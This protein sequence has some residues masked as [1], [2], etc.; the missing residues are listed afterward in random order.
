MIKKLDENSVIRFA[1]YSELSIYNSEIVININGKN[2]RLKGDIAEK[3]IFPIL[4]Y[5]T[6]AN[7]VEFLFRKLE[8]S[9]SK[10]INISIDEFKLVLL[11]LCYKSV[12]IVV[13]D[14]YL[15]NSS[16][17]LMSYYKRLNFEKFESEKICNKKSLVVFSFIENKDILLLTEKLY[18]MI[19]DDVKL[20]F[21]SSNNFNIDELVDNKFVHIEKISCTSEKDKS[22]IDYLSY[23]ENSDFVLAL[24]TNYM[25]D[26][27]KCINDICNKHNK[28]ILNSV[29]N[30]KKIQ[31]GP[32][33]VDKRL[34]SYKSWLQN[35]DD[36]DATDYIN[37]HSNDYLN[38]LSNIYIAIGII[39]DE[40]I[41]YY[42]GL[43]VNDNPCTYERVLSINPVTYEKSI[44]RIVNLD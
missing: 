30:D 39:T 4:D 33:C 34:A 44:Y 5:L 23:I 7:T 3:Y 10:K 28:P 16:K 22:N 17:R 25:S 2:L 38:K 31:V 35:M 1:D 21:I 9:N 26:G 27:M 13:D 11:Q 18:D 20:V 8:E 42:M 41:R 36:N 6:V 40:I 29:V 37:I 32:F 43:Y 19:F 24:G 14:K 15:N 12:I